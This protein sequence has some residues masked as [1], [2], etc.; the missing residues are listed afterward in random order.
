MNKLA[1]ILT[2]LISTI[3]W[4]DLSGNWTGFG[5]WKFKGEGEG[6]YCSPMQ[7]QW[8]ENQN[9]IAIEKG[10]FS[11]EFADMYLEKTAWTIKDGLLFD[12]EQKE[13]GSYDGANL[14]VYMSIPNETTSI[15]IQ[16]KRDGNHYDYQEVWFN[17]VEKIYVIEGRFFTS[18]N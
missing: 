3:S 7:M 9:T 18:G 6:S 10:L 1:L 11:C 14:Q 12:E 16:V 15:H 17:S 4:A 5:T 13:V 2:L 8:S